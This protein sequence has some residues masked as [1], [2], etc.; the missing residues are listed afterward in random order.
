MAT[1]TPDALEPLDPSAAIAR[2]RR[3]RDEGVTDLAVLPPWVATAALIKEK[4]PDTAP[5][6]VRAVDEAVL[7][8]IVAC[9]SLASLRIDNNAIGDDGARAIADNLTALTS[10]DISYNGIGFDG[11]RAI[12]DNLTALTSLDISGNSIRDEGAR[13]IANNLTA[14]TSLHVGHNS[15]GNEGVQAIADNLTALTSLYIW[16]NSIGADGAR[17][18]ASNLTALTSLNI[19]SN[20]IGVGGVR[21]I[22]DKLTTLTSLNIGGN[23]IGDDGARAIADNLTALTSLYI[24]SNSI[25]ADG[26][27]AIAVNLTAL[28]SLHINNNSIGD[29]GARAIADNLTA[30]TSLDIW[31]NS[32]GVG[33]ARAIA[34][35]LTALTSLNIGGNR[36]GDDGARVIADNLTALT[37]LDISRSNI[38][39]D[40]ARA[41][42][43]NLTALTS[44]NIWSNNIGDEGARVIA[45]NLTNLTS[46][47]IGSNSIGVGG[48]RAIADKLTTLTSLNIGGNRIGNDGVRAIADKLNALTSLGISRNHI[49]NDGVRAVLEVFAA[50]GPALRLRYLD[51]SS[52]S[53]EGV[54]AEASRGRDPAAIIS[55]WRGLRDHASQPLNEA[56]MLVLGDE[57]VGKSSLIDF[58]VDDTPR[59]PSH[60]KT[61]GAEIHERIE[62]TGW[63]PEGS[64]VKLNIWDFGGQEIMKGTHRFFLTARSLYVLVVE[65]RR[66]DQ[67]AVHGRIRDWLNTIAAYG[68]DSPVLIVIN[69]H[70]PPSQVLTL[71]EDTLREA[72]PS[73]AAVV[74]TSCNDDDASRE[75][76]SRLR[77]L[78]ANTIAERLPLVQEKIPASWRRV[79]DTIADMARERS[80]LQQGDFRS[81]CEEAEPDDRVSDPN[82]QIALLGILDSLGTIVA[83]GLRADRA[84]AREVH[85]LDPNWLTRAIHT[86][87]IDPRVREAGGV[88]RRADLA[89]VLEPQKYPERRHE[90]IIDMMLSEGV[91]L[92]YPLDGRRD[93]YL[94]PEALPRQYNLD[95]W[96][97]TAPCL[98]FRYPHMPSNLIPRLIVRAHH[99]LTDPPAQYRFGAIFR[100]SRCR[101]L[102]QAI[103]G[104]NMIDVKVKGDD[105]DQPL[106]L[107][108]L[109]AEI[110]GIH[111]RFSG[112]KVS[113]RVPLPENDDADVGVDHL[114]KLLTRFG[115]GH[116]FMPE[117]AHETYAVADLLKRVEPRVDRDAARRRG[118]GDLA[119]PSEAAPSPSV[120]RPPL[121]V[122]IL[123]VVACFVLLGGFVLLAFW[124]VG[125][126]GGVIA[127]AAALIVFIPIVALAATQTGLLDEDQLFGILSKAQ[128]QAGKKLEPPSSP[129][130]SPELPADPPSPPPLPPPLPSANKECDSKDLRKGDP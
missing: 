82:E 21:A 64:A 85:L 4:R 5:V 59:D 50:A 130:S 111:S 6:I 73:L 43:D 58:L 75:S 47:N 53:L 25:G 61:P 45:D 95:E 22:A 44:L 38:G 66:E 102:V 30:L 129:T 7:E 9:S 37:S 119:K 88:F 71:D 39:D 40:G 80:V 60:K 89:R 17:A 14:L 103:P 1:H 18:I 112:L 92:C 121:V 56:K 32:I 78:I 100:A 31:G 77:E 52:N 72:F 62:I 114:R 127:V 13:A 106:A 79:K 10:L 118:S 2:L 108:E 67:E 94:I 49:D 126:V 116:E 86:I 70:E 35:N 97:E 90:F 16:S 46:L 81:V 122:T 20:S 84:A 12:A 120:S 104:A 105:A 128:D 115:P 55:A 99:R 65:A 34:D 19:G 98:R 83:H 8:A 101:V 3:L 91:E 11:A 69:K 125:A 23:R 28:A 24:W 29:D 74:T 96:A 27:R 117:G 48:A 123:G 51:L 54:L 110:N 68:G 57:A 107:A 87:L 63:R 41:I 26:A 124:L 33:G 36:V 42:A 76:V 15:I 109:R 93:A 113:E